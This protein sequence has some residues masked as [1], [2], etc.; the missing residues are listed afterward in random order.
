MENEKLRRVFF[1]IL[2]AGIASRVHAD[3]TVA[4]GALACLRTRAKQLKANGRSAC[5]AGDT[6]QALVAF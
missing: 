4:R 3:V 2:G 5:F 1:N 6:V